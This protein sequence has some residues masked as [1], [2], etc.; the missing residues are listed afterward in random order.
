MARLS[1]ATDSPFM[2]LGAT[3]CPAAEMSAHLSPTAETR[4]SVHYV[5]IRGSY[6][7][8]ARVI[9]ASPLGDSLSR[10]TG[11][12]AASSQGHPT[13]S[14]NCPQSARL[15]ERR[16]RDFREPSVG[17]SLMTGR[18]MPAG[19]LSVWVCKAG[20]FA[21]AT[22]WNLLGK[23]GRDRVAIPRRCP[24]MILD[25]SRHPGSDF[26]PRFCSDCCSCATFVLTP[27][28][29]RLKDHVN[30][31]SIEGFSHAST[32]KFIRLTPVASFFEPKHTVDSGNLA[33]V[34]LSHRSLCYKSLAIL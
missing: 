2:R 5:A 30:A 13:V 11:Q 21:N 31:Q 7:P 9:D 19:I 24:P 3:I 16:L 4:L 10:L 12:R 34:S 20:V 26:V 15:R 22:L 1:K 6:Q 14:R 25:G 28:T 8:L 23:Q 33:S 32:E 18:L 27:Q 17:A 29:S